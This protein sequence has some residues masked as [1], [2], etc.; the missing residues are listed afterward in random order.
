MKW[1]TWRGLVVAMSASAGLMVTTSNAAF[2]PPLEGLD[3]IGS[4]EQW[5]DPCVNGAREAAR[6][7]G[8]AR[9][10]GSHTGDTELAEAERLS[11]IA[12]HACANAER[13]TDALG[14]VDSAAG[15]AGERAGLLGRPAEH[16]EVSM[17]CDAA[18]ARPNSE[19]Q[20]LDALL[21]ADRLAH[22]HDAMSISCAGGLSDMLGAQSRLQRRVDDQ[23]CIWLGEAGRVRAKR[24]ARRLENAEIAA[25]LLAL[26][27]ALRAYDAAQPSCSGLAREDVAERRGAIADLIMTAMQSAPTA[28][29]E[30]REIRLSL[31]EERANGLT[32]F[33]GLE[34]LREE[35][36]FVCHASF[37]GV[38]VAAHETLGGA[39]SGG[40][41]TG[42]GFTA[43]EGLGD[44]ALFGED[45]GDQAAF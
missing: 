44:E 43:H 33:V 7:L 30:A 15:I 40:G 11:A 21:A 18:L 37:E 38:D 13:W 45:T 25:G 26:S 19:A 34:T 29:R 32:E 8:V 28:S 41:L 14:Q 12:A 1:R 31:F 2:A 10:R 6:A 22:V 17:Q 24:G 16:V 5:T 9:L 42:Q 3:C 36:A 23:R 4:P 35:S 39:H 27:G 20:A